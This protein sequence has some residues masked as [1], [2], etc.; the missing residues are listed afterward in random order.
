[1]REQ[2][3]RRLFRFFLLAVVILGCSSLVQA[4]TGLPTDP[5]DPTGQFGSAGPSDLLNG[6]FNASLN[7]VTAIKQLTDTLFWA[8]AGIDFAWT[9]ISLVLH[10]N[11]LQPWL[12][13]LIKKILT[14]GF[15]ATLMQNGQAWTTDIVN[16]FINAGSTAGGR[17]VSGLSASGIMGDGVEL[18]GRMLHGAASVANNTNTSPIG[19]LVGGI[20]NFAPSLILAIGALLIVFAFIM[21]SLHL[22][23]AMV[24]AYVTVG[25]GYLFLGFGGSRWTVPYTQKY[26]GMVVSAGVRIM[27][28]ELVIGMGST[29]IP[30]WQAVADAIAKT[31]D[32]FSGGTP[33]SLWSGVQSEFGLVA[34]I[35]IFALLCWTIPKIAGNVASGSLSMSGGDVVEALSAATNAISSLATAASTVGA[36]AGV[37]GAA[38][39]AQVSQATAQKGSDLGSVSAAASGIGLGAAENVQTPYPPDTVSLNA[40]TSDSH[41]HSVLPPDAGK[42]GSVF[43]SISKALKALPPTGGGM[44]GLPPEMSHGQ[45]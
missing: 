41:S 2:R 8:L 37:S 14:I 15:F 45:E 17:P 27:V 40:S 30:R 23:M 38:A 28:L 42:A 13:G 12:A 25:A 11:E 22:V 19:L 32:I 36:S 20:G 24:E 35:G 18:A 26:L 16:F 31:P 43:S 1:M 39:V 33:G 4:Q 29:L 3:D 21:V 44:Q 6:Y 10:H 9:C 5:G 7:W 34:S